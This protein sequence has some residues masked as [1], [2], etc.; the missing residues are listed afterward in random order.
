MIQLV[1]PTY[2]RLDNQITLNSIP[3]KFRRYI[4][5][6]VQPQEEVAALEIH[7][8]VFVLS[9]DDIGIAQT[10]MEIAREWGCNRQVRHWVLDDDL[11]ISKHIEMKD[12]GLEK[13]SINSRTFSECINEI[14]ASMDQ[15]YFHGG[16]GT[17]LNNPIGKYP[18]NDNFRIV[19]NVFYD[20]S[21]LSDTFQKIDWLLDGA[22]DYYVNLQLLT[23]GKRNRVIYK[24]ITDPGNSNAG[25]GCST[26][27]DVEFHNNAYKKL[28]EEFPDYVT[29]RMK[30]PKSGPWKGIEKAVLSCRWKD[31]YKSS[32]TATIIPFYR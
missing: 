21:V 5:L 9:G 7:P 31:A 16:I 24:F 27:R 19:A 32:Q 28:A 4:T 13:E 26:Y 8:K 12:G 18:Y 1:I 11:K 20:G 23:K 3:K 30:V 29:L 22:E 6:V 14:E 15:G 17:T 2:K 10:R 25:G